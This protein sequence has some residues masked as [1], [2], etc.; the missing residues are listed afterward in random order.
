[1]RDASESGGEDEVRRRR[2]AVV[3]LVLGQA[4]ILGATMTMVFLLQTGES[5]LTYWTAGVS[6][7]ITL[8]SIVLFKSRWKRI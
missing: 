7:L 6:A 2:W 3:R 4:Q 1:M 5:R 8:A